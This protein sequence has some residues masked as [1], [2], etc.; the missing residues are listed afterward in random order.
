MSV[1]GRVNNKAAMNNWRQQVQNV[2]S[3]IHTINPIFGIS[4]SANRRSR[5]VMQAQADDA[6]EEVQAETVE[7]ANE[8]V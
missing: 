2:K 7:V 3:S 5:V 4:A 1:S 8:E 6:G